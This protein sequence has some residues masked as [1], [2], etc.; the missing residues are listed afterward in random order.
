MSQSQKLISHLISL[1][2]PRNIE[3]MQRFGINSSN[4]LGI[5]I[6]ILRQ[7]A[8]S[9]FKDHQLALD[10]WQSGFHE[11]R[12]LA[13]MIDDP[14]QLT[15]EQMDEW[16]LDFNSWDICDQVCSNLF[17]KTKIFNE[18]IFEYSKRNEEFVKRSA[19]AMIA[20]FAV[21]GKKEKDEVFLQFFELIE[22]EC[23]D[24]RIYVKKAVNWALRQIGKRNYELCRHSLELCEKLKQ[25]D[26]P[27][28]RWISNDAERELR[29]KFKI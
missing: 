27:I 16:V 19:F 11:A 14:K 22:N 7:L 20:S 25:V 3:G 6:P 15:H 21:K 10:L 23:C 9:H 5:R 12:I 24:S 8:K 26:S 2:N 18:K 13:S 4:A 28:A 1:K 29:L 17:T